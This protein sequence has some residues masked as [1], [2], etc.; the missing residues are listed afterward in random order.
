MT[1][2][3]KSWVY[4]TTWLGNGQSI[5]GQGFR[6]ILWFVEYSLI[7]NFGD[8]VF[9]HWFSDTLVRIILKVLL[10]Y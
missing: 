10:S 6:K 1:S 2:Q 8:T 7:E 5:F 9:W 4:Y 3:T